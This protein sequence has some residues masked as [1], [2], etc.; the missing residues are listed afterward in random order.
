[1]RLALQ[2][3]ELERTWGGLSKLYSIDSQSIEKQYLS[4][5]VIGLTENRLT[6]EI[7]NVYKVRDY[8]TDASVN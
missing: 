6:G 2:V 4:I 1:M 5:S 8:A 3:W 7:Q